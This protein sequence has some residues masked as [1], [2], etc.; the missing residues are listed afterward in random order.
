MSIAIYQDQLHL[1]LHNVLLLQLTCVS[2]ILVI[3]MQIAFPVESFLEDRVLEEHRTKLLEVEH[4]MV[5]QAMALQHPMVVV[6]VILAVLVALEPID[7]NAE[8]VL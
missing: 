6:Q 7:V 4:F 2:K 5:D 3:P 8:A 1:Y